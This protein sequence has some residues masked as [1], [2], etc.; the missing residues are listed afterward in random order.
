MEPTR[1]VR[2]R[3]R[4]I[5]TTYGPTTVALARLGIDWWWRMF[6]HGPAA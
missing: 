5:V 6:R 4:D 3:L 2:E 1:S